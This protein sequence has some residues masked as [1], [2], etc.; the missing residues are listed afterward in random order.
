MLAANDAVKAGGSQTLVDSIQD[1]ISLERDVSSAI[2][3]IS[4]TPTPVMV[5]VSPVGFMPGT[6]VGTNVL[7]SLGQDYFVER[8]PQQARGILERRIAGIWFT[9]SRLM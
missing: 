6:I 2:A 4:S 8:T 1:L 5:P 9:H 7:V 3:S